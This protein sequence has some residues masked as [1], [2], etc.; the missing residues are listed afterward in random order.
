[1]FQYDNIC[2]IY[3]LILLIYILL[4][5]QN[6]VIIFLFFLQ[7]LIYIF[8]RS[9]KIKLG[10]LGYKYF[11]Y[12]VCSMEAF[13]NLHISWQRP[14]LLYQIFTQPD[15]QSCQTLQGFL[16]SVFE[17]NPRYKETELSKFWNT[18]EG[19]QKI[20]IIFGS[21]RWRSVLEEK[22]KIKMIK[23]NIGRRSALL[24]EFLV[25]SKEKIRERQSSLRDIDRSFHEPSKSKNFKNLEN[26]T[27]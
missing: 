3:F 5:L 19:K 18:P 12:S 14:S 20:D 1:M 17:R 6:F 8:L 9:K 23:Q 16:E 21:Q 15:L 24:R 4:G 26:K 10:R 2:I 27:L 7:S 11:S 25:P 22:I 13:Y